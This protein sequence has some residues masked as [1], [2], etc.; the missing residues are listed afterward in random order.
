VSRVLD[1]K[2]ESPAMRERFVDDVLKQL[3]ARYVL[4]DGTEVEGQSL[5]YLRTALSSRLYGAGDR[6][7]R[8]RGLSRYGD[9]VEA[10]REAGFRVE[11]GRG[12]RYFR[13]GAFKPGQPCDVVTV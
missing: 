8:W 13:G 3:C 11:R 5:S 10:L 9:F 12:Y 4:D 6:S 2:F 7:A 1:S